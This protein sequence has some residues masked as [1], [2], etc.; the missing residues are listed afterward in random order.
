MSSR[1]RQSIFFCWTD[2]LFE[3]RQDKEL[4]HFC[5]SRFKIMRWEWPKYVCPSV[6]GV[7]N[8][9]S[10]AT[11]NKSTNQ[12]G[13]WNCFKIIKNHIF[14]IYS[15]ECILKIILSFSDVRRYMKVYKLPH[16]FKDLFIYLHVNVWTRRT[17][18]FIFD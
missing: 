3:T 1:H 4:A 14:L 12:R 17:K 7:K 5:I 6:L 15:Q 18:T 10:E 16:W 9:Q 13:L 2:R 11:S 8:F